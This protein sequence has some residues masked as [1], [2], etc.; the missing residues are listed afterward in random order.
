MPTVIRSTSCILC[1]ADPRF[2]RKQTKS[3][4][5]KVKEVFPVIDSST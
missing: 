5:H 3:N 2:S 1:Y 4:V